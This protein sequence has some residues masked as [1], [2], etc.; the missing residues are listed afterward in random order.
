MIDGA[1][2]LPE[3]SLGMM[4]ASAIHNPSTPRAFNLRINDAVRIAAHAAGT[5]RVVDGVRYFADPGFER[6]IVVV[7]DGAPV[8][9]SHIG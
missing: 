6:R 7:V 8:A 1:L 3:T 5:D 2:V 4:L 9:C